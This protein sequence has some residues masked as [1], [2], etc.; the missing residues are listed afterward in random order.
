VHPVGNEEISFGRFRLDLIHPELRRDGQPVRLHRRALGVL[1]A[2]AE[3]KGEIVSKDELMARLWPGRIVEE[4]N[5]HVHV[6][7]LR[8]SLD[9][10]GEGHKFVVT[11]PGRGY[12]LAD[13]SGE[14]YSADGTVEAFSLGRFRLD[15]ARRELLRDGQ[16]LR[17][18]RHPLSIL[19]ALAEARGGV[20]SRGELIARLWPGRTVEEGNLHVHVSALRK[21]L[22]GHGGGHSLI[23]TVLGGYRLANPGSRSVHLAEDSVPPHL[24]LPDRPSI[25]VMPFQNFGGDPDEEYFADGMVEE[26]ITALSR[27]RWLFVIARNSSFT[28]KDQA[29]DVK[30]IGRELGVRYVLEGSVRKAGGRVRITA[31]LIEAE[32]EAHLWA[33]RFD[34]SLEAI[35]DLQDQ[36]AISVAGV[37]E[38]TLQAAEIRR[39]LNQP[40]NNPTTYDLYSRA[41]RT[42]GAWEKKDYLEAL[43]WL[44]QAIKQDATYGPAL[45]LSALYHTALS[46]TGW[47]E[48]PETARQTA[49]SLARRAVRNAGDDA[50]T[51]G[52]AAY[53]LAYFGEDIDAATALIDRSLQINPSFA[54]GWLWS[55]WLRLWAGLPDVAI[56]HFERSSRLNPR[57][58]LG[59]KLMATGVAHFF[60]RRLDQAR[61]IL[62]LSL[63]QHPNWVPTNRFLAACY[64][65]LGQLDEAKITI[66]RLRGLTPVVLPSADNWRD[67]EQ[68]E[69]YL[70]GLRLAM[71]AT[72][73]AASRS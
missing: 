31:Q 58:P 40:R 29:V 63:Q 17:L 2:L 46:A 32:T 5:L 62:S 36:V 25:A 57:A 15:F 16:P 9:E 70:S 51:L 66:E 27:I 13:L 37:I 71:S 33:E 20:V 6:S 21:A 72:D 30:R 39:A 34:G 4:G 8:K 53:V 35:F 52:R 64:A 45:A 18:H 3:A 38:P 54:D 47:A 48:E 24:P 14:E 56:D 23:V 60:A 26:I 67:L 42:T 73:E 68:R 12:R 59:G 55:G 7:A 19:C 44:S 50:A 61:T 49:I 10:H 1:C 69:F 28:Y 65:H 22:D 11:V 41:L 43:D